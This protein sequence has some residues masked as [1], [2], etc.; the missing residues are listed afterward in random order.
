MSGSDGRYISTDSGPTA[1]NNASTAVSAKVSGRSMTHPH[2]APPRAPGKRP[3][4][5]GASLRGC[6]LSASLREKRRIG[7]EGRCLGRR[8]RG[9]RKPIAA[10]LV[11]V[12]ELAST[13]RGVQIEAKAPVR[14][15]VGVQPQPIHH[16]G[17]VPR[18]PVGLIEREHRTLL[19]KAKL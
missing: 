2:D 12:A 3:P 6:L 11:R 18:P 14:E 19:S 16:L 4:T 1:V 8:F 10:H 17:H 9:S 13:N 7:A 15:R 5:T